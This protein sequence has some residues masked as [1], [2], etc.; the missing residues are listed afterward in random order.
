MQHV[1]SAY[2]DTLLGL[3]AV[4]LP[5]LAVTSELQCALRVP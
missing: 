1:V 4:E 2:K 5:V 3:P